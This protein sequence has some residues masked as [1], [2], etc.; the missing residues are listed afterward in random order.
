[1]SWRIVVKV[2]T[3][4]WICILLAAVYG[5][6]IN[7]YDTIH[8]VTHGAPVDAMFIVRI[9]GIPLPVLGAILGYIP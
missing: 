6:I 7:L 2:G 8:L 4:A 5:W 9:I 3:R 1:M